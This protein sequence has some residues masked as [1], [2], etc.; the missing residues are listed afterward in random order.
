[1]TSEF[2]PSGE[3][4]AQPEEVIVMGCKQKF[5]LLPVDSRDSGTRI[6]HNGR[7]GFVQRQPRVCV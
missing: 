5:G 6:T 7:R 3:R 4:A 1:M 2:A